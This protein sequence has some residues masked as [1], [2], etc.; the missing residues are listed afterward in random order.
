MP[1]Q[2]LQDF[3]D[4]WSGRIKEMSAKE[5]SNFWR[6][7]IERLS[8]PSYA[9]RIDKIKIQIELIK[10]AWTN[11][12]NFHLYSDRV[13]LGLM[14]AMSYHVGD[15]QGVK[16][17]YRKDII[18]EVLIGPI[19]QVGNPEYMKW[20]GDDC[21]PR[22]LQAI[23]SFL[24]DKINSPQHRNHH[25]ALSEWSSDLKWLEDN[26]EE[27]LESCRDIDNE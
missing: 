6:V 20:W 11:P 24:L 22:R 21:S 17:S 26:G 2:E 12:D 8:D 7:C 14:G 25:R 4:T 1:S 19:P 18:R 5:L 16:D 9:N 27:I 3:K 23:K 15:T 13:E 10:T